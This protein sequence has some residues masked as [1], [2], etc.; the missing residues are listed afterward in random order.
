MN[1][2]FKNE[3]M[4]SIKWIYWYILICIKTGTLDSLSKY[5]VIEEIGKK[6]EVSRIR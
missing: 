2:V 5:N 4:I 3:I 1:V 6:Q